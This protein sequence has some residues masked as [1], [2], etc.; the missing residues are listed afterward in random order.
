[1]LAPA[2]KGALL[3]FTLP[4]A[5]LQACPDLRPKLYYS[6]AN[7]PSSFTS[8][9]PA[10]Y[11]LGVPDTMAP[12]DLAD[13]QAHCLSTLNWYR[14]VRSGEKRKTKGGGGGVRSEVPQIFHNTVLTS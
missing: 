10:A 4:C 1:M 7:D 13:L 9:L 6:A 8:P 12:C 5:A 14:E 2:I 11:S 3:L